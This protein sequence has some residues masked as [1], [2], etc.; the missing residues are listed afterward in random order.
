MEEF[1]NHKRERDT[2]ELNDVISFLKENKD[3]AYTV[4]E[5]ISMGVLPDYE[6]SKL[7]QLSFR[8]VL[9][10]VTIGDNTYFTIKEA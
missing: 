5:L 10:T 1:R 2:G 4:A 7:Y 3:K 9:V 6:E 8:E